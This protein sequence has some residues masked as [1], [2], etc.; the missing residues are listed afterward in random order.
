MPERSV[1][2][3]AFFA[4][5]VLSLY[6]VH[7][8]LILHEVLGT[9]RAAFY[10]TLA[11]VFA[12]LLGF[13]ITALSI[14]SGSVIQPRLAAVVQAGYAHQIRRLFVMTIASTGFGSIASLLALVFDSDSSPNS[15]LATAV[16][17]FLVATVVAI[18]WCVWVLNVVVFMLSHLPEPNAPTG[19]TAK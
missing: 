15:S 9:N 14:F 10:G 2:L 3:A 12:A 8:P 19:A 5:A 1:G 17:A 16:I 7:N 4:V 6:C 11:S 13:A 18:F